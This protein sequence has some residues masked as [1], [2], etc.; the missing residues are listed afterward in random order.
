MW[1]FDEAA[2]AEA[3]RL[4]V[5]SGGSA[6]L[7]SSVLGFAMLIPMQPWGRALAGK[8]NPKQIGAAHLDWIVLGLMV[9]LAAQVLVLFD[10][11][12]TWF[13]VI[14]LAVGAWLNPLPYVFRA[15][16]VNAFALSGPPHQ[17]AAASLGFISSLGIIYGWTAVLL[18]AASG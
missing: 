17:V 1:L 6:I 9:G 13:A 14:A 15:F 10:V 3:A 16:G 2:S 8:A 5:F 18:A 12:V 7:F 11:R 4:L